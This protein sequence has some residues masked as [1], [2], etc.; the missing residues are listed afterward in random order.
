[1]IFT[2]TPENPNTGIYEQNL[3]K[4]RCFTV[5]IAMLSRFQ[6]YTVCVVVVLG[7]FIQTEL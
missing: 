4:P 5:A 2:D 1:M 3:S 6:D 7:R